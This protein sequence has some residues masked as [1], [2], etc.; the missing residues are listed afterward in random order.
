MDSK[1]IAVTEPIQKPSPIFFGPDGLRAGWSLLV[2]VALF[3]TL[4]KT[5]GFIL[6]LAH[7]A[8]QVEAVSATPGAVLYSESLAFLIVATVAWIMSRIERRPVSTYGL[9]GQRRIPLLLAGAFWG[10]LF[11][12][13]LVLILIKAG[14]LIV[15]ARL[16]HGTDIIRYALAWTPSF[17]AIAFFEEYLFRGYLLYTLSRGFAGLYRRIANPSRSAS[18]G[19]WT[20]AFLLSVG[21]GL[22]HSSNAGESPVGLFCA[23]FISLIFCLSIWRTGSL[24]WAIGFHA[25]WDWA[26]SFLYGVADSGVTVR[27]H[28]LA[29]HP[30]GKPLFSGGAT[31]PE[32]SLFA[33]PIAV[34]TGLIIV[35]TL[36]GNGRYAALLPPLNPS[37]ASNTGSL[38]DPV[39]APRFEEHRH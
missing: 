27:F 32:G 11:L 5:S 34:L 19:F 9:G 14:F 30:L 20:A 33:I 16:L 7:I 13:L 1:R 8:P 38:P 39:P 23:A 22:I 29:T 21:F 26:E 15:D 25:A 2:A 10:L 18:M 24:W 35:I 4:I 28:L 3:L 37:A 17:L 6:R 36:R 31:G 12:S